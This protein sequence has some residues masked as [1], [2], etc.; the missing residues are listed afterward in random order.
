MFSIDVIL[1]EDEDGGFVVR[2]P[3]FPGCVSQGETEEAAMKNIVDALE[4]W[5]K[6]QQD[7]T[8]QEWSANDQ[9]YATSKR[10]LQF[11]TVCSP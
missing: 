10:E 11:T 8:L 4:L 3:A 2:C 1:E 7:K 5:L 9:G 6:T